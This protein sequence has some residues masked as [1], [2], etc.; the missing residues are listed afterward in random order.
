M[1]LTKN[2]TQCCG[3]FHC[4]TILLCHCVV[5][6]AVCERHGDLVHIVLAYL[7]RSAGKQARCQTPL[8]TFYALPIAGITHHNVATFHV[9]FFLHFSTLTSFQT[10]MS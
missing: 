10:I 2:K 5:C 9:V 3:D 6:C 8:Y 4:L 1:K 7:R